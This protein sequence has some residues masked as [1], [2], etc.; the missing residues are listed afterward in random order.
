MNKPLLEIIEEVGNALYGYNVVMKEFN[1]DDSDGIV[2]FTTADADEIDG[3]KVNLSIWTIGHFA[4][5][6]GIEMVWIGDEEKNRLHYCNDDAN[7][8]AAI[9][10][11]A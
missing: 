9:I 11:A 3:E 5:V 1:E 7:V 8:I 4:T 10:Y 6:E 2:T